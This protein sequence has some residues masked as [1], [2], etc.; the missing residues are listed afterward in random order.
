VLSAT[1]GTCNWSY[2]S[3]YG[4]D[5]VGINSL[6]YPT[7]PKN[8][9]IPEFSIAHRVQSNYTPG[10]FF[11][12]EQPSADD[13]SPASFVSHLV[14]LQAVKTLVLLS[15]LMFASVLLHVENAFS[16]SPSDAK[17]VSLPK[18][19]PRKLVEGVMTV[20]PPDPNAQDTALGPYDLD[21]VAKHPELAWT[22]PDF[23][24]NKPFYAS[25]SETL[26][27]MSREVT[28]R[29]DV[30]GLEFSFKPARL[31]EVDVPMASGKMQKKVVWY[32]LYKVRYTGEDLSPQVDEGSEIPA[33]PNKV[34]FKSVRFLPR[35][36]IVSKERNLNLDADI[37]P[38]AVK[39]IA[40]RER[41][42]KPIYDHIEIGK[43]DI[44][45]SSIDADNSLW[46][47]ATWTNVDPR[48]DFFAIDVRGLTN[49]YRIRSDAAGKKSFD[50]K[51][52][53]IYFWRPGDAIDE[54]KDRILL[55]LPALE[56]KTRQ[57]YYL[58]QFN[59]KE[60]LDY[61]WIYR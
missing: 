14:D 55:G 10:K 61:Q 13:R 53:R 29:H 54:S 41:V 58:Q 9:T 7:S 15:F 8:S 60:R 33:S 38:S 36:S 32:L 47:V 43:M 45:P 11:C 51:T 28:F 57:E 12:W 22:A 1:L 40:D 2:I 49:A 42:G 24:E 19:A 17:P 21:L 59:L 25:P 56:N 3:T 50:R 26:L 46:G 20:V 52:L 30:W 37:L 35:F 27:S 6:A 23:P 5:F 18:L 16:Q 34:R 31:I 48:L 44:E 39:A 4:A